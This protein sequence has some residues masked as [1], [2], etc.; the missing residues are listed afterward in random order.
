MIAQYIKYLRDLRG[1]SENTASSYA[2]D[3]QH[4]TIWAKDNV[5]DARWSAITRQDI[6]AYI[7]DLVAQGMK[8]ATTNRRLSAISGLY[9]YMKRQGYN[10]DNPCKYESRRKVG[11]AIPNTIPV[12]DLLKAYNEA[13]GVV[14]VMLGL[15]MTT[16]IRIQELLDIKWEDINFATQAITINGKGN[17]QRI[18]Y[19]TEA[20]LEVLHQVSDIKPMTGRIF[21]MNQRDARRMIY[22]ALKPYSQAKQLSPH[23]IR[24]TFATNIANQGANVTTLASMLGHDRIETTQRYIDMSQANTKAMY[25]IHSILH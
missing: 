21:T 1:Y 19:T 23:A 10:I 17:K 9:R 18:V 13:Y 5:S 25:Q 16:G 15:L 4:F 12:E 24:H 2:K 8:P 3:L 20:Q 6:D 7:V 11:M 14:K 22:D